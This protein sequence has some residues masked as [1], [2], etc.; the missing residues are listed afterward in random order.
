MRRIAGTLHRGLPGGWEHLFQAPETNG[1]TGIEVIHPADLNDTLQTWSLDEKILERVFRDINILIHTAIG[2]GIY[3]AR[4]LA[5]TSPTCHNTQGPLCLS[6]LIVSARVQYARDHRAWRAEIAHIYMR[7]TAERAERLSRPFDHSN[8]TVNDLVSR[9]KDQSQEQAERFRQLTRQELQ[10]AESLLSTYQSN[11]A[12]DHIPLQDVLSTTHHGDS[13]TSSG[14]LRDTGSFEN[15]LGLFIGNMGDNRMEFNIQKDGLLR[16]IQDATLKRE[17]TMNNRQQDV[18]EE[19]LTDIL[20]GSLSTCFK[21]A[22]IQATFHEWWQRTYPDLR[23]RPI[24]IECESAIQRFG[25]TELPTEECST[26]SNVTIITAYSWAVIVPYGRSL[27]VML[28]ENNLNTTVVDCKESLAPSVKIKNGDPVGDPLGAVVR[29]SVIQPNG[30][31]HPVQYLA[32][33]SMYRRRVSR[34]ILDVLRLQTASAFMNVPLPQVDLSQN[35]IQPMDP[36]ESIADD[37][38]Q[39]VSRE[40]RGS[41]M[42]SREKS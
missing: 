30:S 36:P 8:I 33:W 31:F 6:T 2:D 35:P 20:K 37:D 22:G 27:K 18:E 39:H 34:L 14:N 24:S 15:L 42:S 12:L 23:G 1:S 16:A 5:Y 10:T 3:V 13:L 41:K 19:D 17:Q 29:W 26:A 40:E 11:W 38:D 32:H 4:G 21:Q 7:S 9:F 28:L 25:S